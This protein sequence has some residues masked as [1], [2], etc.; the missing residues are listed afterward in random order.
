MN[1]EINLKNCTQKQKDKLKSSMEMETENE[2][3]KSKFSG[4]SVLFI[5]H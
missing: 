2:P 1:Y 3:V 5:M 4:V